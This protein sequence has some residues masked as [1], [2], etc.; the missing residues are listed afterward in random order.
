MRRSR[1]TFLSTAAL[2]LALACVLAGCDA[3]RGLPATP[4]DTVESTTRPTPTET[5]LRQPRLAGV[6]SWA[7]PL[8][9][10]LDDETIDRLADVDLVVVDGEEATATQVKALKSR[11]AV[12]LAYLS[13]GTIEP[14]RSWYPQVEPYRLEKWADWDE[15]FADT[16]REEFR[17]TIMLDVAPTILGKGFDGLFL[18]NVDMIEDHPAQTAGVTRLVEGL[19]VLVH[20]DGGIVALQNGEDVMPPFLPYIDVWNREDVTYTYNFEAEEYVRVSAADH[21]AAIRTLARMRALGILTLAL[22][23]P[24]PLDANALAEAAGAAESVGAI[25]WTSDIDLTRT[26]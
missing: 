2:A 16:S 21:D 24:P 3:P 9:A 7:M 4:S 19:A 14:W 18:D 8:G 17:S 25:S 11:G 12:V 13:I 10:T 20:Q 23:Y 6:R 15:Y 5:E 26:D 1:V 22:D